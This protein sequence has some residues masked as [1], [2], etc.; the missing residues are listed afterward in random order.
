[1][2]DTALHF[3]LFI[4]SLQQRMEEYRQYAAVTKP[5]KLEDK[6]KLETHF[7]TLQ[8]KLR[9][10]NRPAYIPSEGKLVSDINLRWKELET[11]EKAYEEYL[12]SELRRY[13]RLQYVS[14]ML[15]LH[16]VGCSAWSILLTSSIARH[17]NS[18]H[19]QRVRVKCSNVLTISKR[20]TLPEFR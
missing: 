2:P 18:S 19:G 5:P 9:V 1:M 4:F 11:R 3:C 8:T 7:H 13:D 20:L 16:I 15:Y 14:N 17:K 12:L 6:G 10:S